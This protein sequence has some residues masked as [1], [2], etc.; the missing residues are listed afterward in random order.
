QEGETA[1][2]V[3]D[4]L[5]SGGSVLEGI[6]KLESSGLTVRDV[7]VF[8]DHGASGNGGARQHLAGRGYR[9]HAVVDIGGIT[10]V[11]RAAGRISA[12]QAATLGHRETVGS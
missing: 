1:V 2:V 7:V 6:G 9:C 5:I 4:I 3:D 12:S 10:A 11:L 8:I